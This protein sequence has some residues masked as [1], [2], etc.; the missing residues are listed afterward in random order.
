MIVV[1]SPAKAEGLCTARLRALDYVPVEELIRTGNR[2]VSVA[3][4]L[5]SPEVLEPEDQVTGHGLAFVHREIDLDMVW[6]QPAFHRLEE[7]KR[8]GRQ[9]VPPPGFRQDGVEDS[10]ALFVHSLFDSYSDAAS[11]AHHIAHR[12][13]VE[14]LKQLLRAPIQRQVVVL[15]Y[16][17]CSQR[18]RREMLDRP[19]RTD[20]DRPDSSVPGRALDKWQEQGELFRR[21]YQGIARRGEGNADE[22]SSEQPAFDSVDGQPRLN[23]PGRAVSQAEETAA[24]VRKRIFDD[25]LPLG[26]VIDAAKRVAC[27][28]GIPFG[29]V[30][31]RKP[32]SSA[33]T[34]C[35]VELVI[36]GGFGHGSHRVA[37]GGFGRQMID[38]KSTRLNSSHSQISYAVFCLKKKK[39]PECLSCIMVAHQL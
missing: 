21:R 31:R 19:R 18:R 20:L 7:S 33:G 38:R 16:H 2:R 25:L 34:P 35:C 36:Y 13:V 29:V 3:R 14:T 24:D 37:M 12:R 11:L 30:L 28:E 26:E 4:I 9:R 6:A 15:V 17:A 5:R 8:M 22:A 27:D 39:Q 32:V 10:N 23:L 1:R